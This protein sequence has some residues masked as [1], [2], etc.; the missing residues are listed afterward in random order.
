MLFSSTI[1]IFI[2]LPI[3]LLGFQALGRFGR[4]AVFSWLSLMSCIFY[5][6]WNPKYLL[7]LI[8]SILLNFAA[9]KLIVRAKSNPSLQSF[10]LSSA[11]ICNLL[12]LVWFKYLFPILDFFHSVGLSSHAW[13]NIILPLGISFFTFTE[14][15]Y[16]IDLKEGIAEEQDLLSYVLF[17]TFFPHLIAGPIIHHSDMMPQFAS[18]KPGGLRSDDMM[19]GITWFCLGLAKKVLIAD[20]TAPIA[21]LFYAHA[22][23]YGALSAWTGV[24]A[25]AIQ[26]YFDFSGYSDMAIGL[27][28]MFSIEF[29]INFNSPYKS[30]GMIE[31]WQRWHMTLSMYL[32]VYLYNPIAMY[33]N[34]RRMDAGKKVSKKAMKTFEGF[35]QLVAFPVLATMLIAGIWHGAGLQ[36]ICFGLLHGIYIV[37]NHAWRIFVPHDSTWQ[38]LLPAPVSVAITFLAVVVSQVFFRA[39]GV[40]QATYILGSMVGRHGHGMLDGALLQGK[41]A[42]TSPST[43]AAFFALSFFI[44]WAMPNTQELLNQVKPDSATNFSLAPSLRWHPTFTWA[45]AVGLLCIPILMRLDQSTNF[46]YFQF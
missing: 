23:Q 25:Y 16:L 38:K 22:S 44:I 41:S 18:R 13:G 15:A 42:P 24:L 1:F 30:K 3:T 31:F 34:R 26:L 33:L 12:L 29:P 19:V 4:T 6:Y 45:V 28:R 32:N 37:T 21:D 7:L 14:I 35:S 46:L 27:A 11:V 40:G 20:R 17:V 43:T 39:N 10:Y 5:G 2:F 9:A 36:Y 8:A